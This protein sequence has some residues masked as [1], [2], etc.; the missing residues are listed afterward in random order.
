[1][2]IIKENKHSVDEIVKVLKKGGLAI[3]LSGVCYN[4]GVDATNPV[5]VKKLVKYK[6]RPFGKPFSIGVKNLA[7][8]KEYVEMNK[9]AINLYKNFY[10]GPL[11]IICKGKH[12]VAP[13]IESELGT[14]GIFV[15]DHKLTTDIVGE[16]GKPVTTTSAN[17]SYQ[18]RP[19]SLESLFKNLSKKQMSLIDLA[20]DSGKAP[21]REASTVIDTTL[22]DPAIL[23]QGEIRLKDK[24]EILSTGEET[25]QNLGKELWQ[26]YERFVAKR[27]L[28]FAL[29]GPMGAGKTQF[30]KGLG[31]AMGIADDIISPTFNLVLEYKP[32][33]GAFALNHID[34]WRL[35][36]PNELEGLGFIKMLEEKR[37]VIAIE[38]ADRVAA[39]IKKHRDESTVIWVRI[40]Y[41]KKE[42]ERLISW[43]VL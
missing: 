26:K 41:G 25:T 18:P 9:T 32:K 23:R 15:T 14:L 5:A 24:D 22:D 35:E 37:M 34:A 17:A 7:M 21:E 38:W 28:I 3:F 36:N 4:A 11:T 6:N 10:P 40:N 12:M 39:T 20:V 19:F 1:M 29:E 16:L 43:G 33:K 27:P 30:T 31:R 8:A 2:K 13:G 42:N